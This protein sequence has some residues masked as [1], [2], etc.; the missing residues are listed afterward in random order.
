[1]RYI[2]LAHELKIEDSYKSN[3]IYSS[4]SVKSPGNISKCLVAKGEGHDFGVKFEVLL[5]YSSEVIK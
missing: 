3:L 5:N 2:H 4:I 1:M